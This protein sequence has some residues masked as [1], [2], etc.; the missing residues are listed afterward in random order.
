MPSGGQDT[1]NDAPSRKSATV[2]SHPSQDS[3]LSRISRGGVAIEAQPEKGRCSMKRQFRPKPAPRTIDDPPL[4]VAL[5]A[6]DI[7]RIFG[8]SLGSVYTWDRNGLLRR[9]ALSKPMGAHRWSGRL[10]DRFLNGEDNPLEAI[11]R[12]A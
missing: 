1:A 9:F 7:S 11:R 4:P 3:S 5:T 12:R 2:G 10:V 6:R 8:I